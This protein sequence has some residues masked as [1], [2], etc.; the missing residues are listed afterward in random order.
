MDN[1]IRRIDL[2]HARDEQAR[3]L[4]RR[5]WLVTNGLGGY[6]SGTISGTV[7]WR[8]HGLLIAALPT[9]FG[10]MVM[11]NHLA[12]FLNFPDG[13]TI[14][15]GGEEPSRPEDPLSNGHYVA[16]FRVE[17]HL[18]IWRFELDD[19]AIEK[20]VLLLHGQNTVH[21]TYRL[22]SKQE[23]IRLQLRPSMH[24]RPHEYAVNE[25]LGDGYR[26]SMLGDRYEISLGENQ[27]S[28]R[29]MFLADDAV[30]AHD[31]GSKREIFY[32]KE[33]ERGYASR[34]LLWSPGYFQASLAQRRD[35]TL[36][37]LTVI[38]ITMLALSPEEAC[39]WENERRK[40][41]VSLANPAAQSGPAA[42]LVLAA[43]QFI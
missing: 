21:V 8:Y 15:I 31:R 3:Q 28:L 35:I 29:L 6:A 4:L 14:Q 25:P 9:P 32:L 12:E 24:F 5:E 17:N 27:P 1:L 7:T 43:D 38:W 41:L 22:L 2:A 34:G 23:Y 30:F 10:R 37:A 33:S 11:L 39:Y 13:R 40:R 16:E 42:E 19:I 36:I 18:P 20:R 26:L